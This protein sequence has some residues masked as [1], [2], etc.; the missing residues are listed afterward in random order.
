[1]LATGIEG[2][3]KQTMISQIKPVHVSQ[4]AKRRVHIFGVGKA[5]ASVFILISYIAACESILLFPSEQTFIQAPFLRSLI[6]LLH[7]PYSNHWTF[8]PEQSESFTG[9]S[10]LSTNSGRAKRYLSTSSL[11]RPPGEAAVLEK[12]LQPS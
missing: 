9:K 12:S 2:V 8:L 3:S 10:F 11:S 6:I 5:D 1:M 7:S 4:L